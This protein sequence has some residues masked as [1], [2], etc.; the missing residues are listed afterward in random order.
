MSD[1]ALVTRAYRLSLRNVDGLITALALPVMLMLMFVYLFGG[2]INV[3]GHYVDRYVDYVVPGV[4]LV[5]VGFG[6][7]T[8]G[9]QRFA[10]S[11]RRHHRPFPLDGRARRG[12]HQQSRRGER[13]PKPG[14]VTAGFRG[15]VR[16]RLPLRCERRRLAR[17]GRRA[18]ALRAGAVRFAATVGILARSPEAA[19]GMTFLVSFL[20]YA[21]SAFVP[22]QQHAWMAQGSPATSR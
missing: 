22:I 10:R 17:R 14:V 7:A 21:S 16:D 8:N 12:A 2:A 15:G 11:D 19:N 4:L 6:A 13:G 20:P 5:C 18:H 3:G 9:G 1:H